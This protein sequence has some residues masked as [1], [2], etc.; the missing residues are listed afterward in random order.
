MGWVPVPP[1]SPYDF[2]NFDEPGKSS[3]EN[4]PLHRCFQPFSDIAE[5][6]VMVFTFAF[7]EPITSSYFQQL[8]SYVLQNPA[9]DFFVTN[10][11]IET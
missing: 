8:N 3:M 4:T 11:T 9:L 5:N 2:P 10:P 7:G 6:I 1:Y